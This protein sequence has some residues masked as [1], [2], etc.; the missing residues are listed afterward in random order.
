MKKTTLILIGVLCALDCS[1]KAE[2]AA[3]AASIEAQVVEA[4][5]PAEK[6]VITEGKAPV[7]SNEAAAD[8]G[9]VLE[10][11]DVAEE[12]AAAPVANAGDA[13]VTAD[14]GDVTD[15]PAEKPNATGK[16]R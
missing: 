1:V 2:D 5:A 14:A 6:Q 13:A 3:V 10:T 8:A 7:A 11:P 15:N 12:N 4:P 16:P 9:V